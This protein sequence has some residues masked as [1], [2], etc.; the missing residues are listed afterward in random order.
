VARVT[1]DDAWAKL[2][3][4]RQHFDQL[5]PE[6]EDFEQRDTHTICVEVDAKT[7]TYTFYVHGLDAPDPYWGL[8]IGDILHN[9]RVALDY[10]A[11]SLV[12][13][14]REQEPR[15]IEGVSFPVT[16]DPQNFRIGGGASKEPLFGGYLTRIE[17]LQPYNNGNPSIWGLDDK[18]PETPSMFPLGRPPRFSPLPD[19]LYRLIDLDNIGKHR[20]IHAVWLGADWSANLASQFPGIPTDFREKGGTCSFAPL[21]D[22]AEIGSIRFGTP[23]PHEW[24]PGKVDMKRH[25]PLRVSLDEAGPMNQ[26]LATLPICLWAAEAILTIFEPVFSHGEPPLPVTAVGLPQ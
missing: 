8:R 4:S 24:E 25:F 23:L 26:V 7:G 16:A 9:A 2:N 19:A 11:V 10:L 20:V 15:D 1:L 13:F 6:I 14:V 5:R 3:W 17:E 21:E 18:W 12:A 22:G